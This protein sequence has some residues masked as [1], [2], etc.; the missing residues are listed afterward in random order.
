MNT[1]LKYFKNANLKKTKTMTKKLLILLAPILLTVTSCQTEKDYEADEQ[2]ITKMNEQWDKNVMTDN[3]KNADYFT[4]DGILVE[5]GKVYEGKE[6]IA[7]LF[8]TYQEDFT[9]L[10][11]KKTIDD[12]KIED[13]L[14]TVRGLYSGSFISKLS[15][16]TLNIKGAWVDLCEKQTGGDWKM[17]Y[18]I[19]TELKD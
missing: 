10:N 15:G 14:A 17:V 11:S 16:D 13:D 1:L 5:N 19:G 12:V 4:D 2:A 6:A 7:N 9:V 3:E 18:S 8:K